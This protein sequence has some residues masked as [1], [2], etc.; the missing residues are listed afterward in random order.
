MD[1]L[2]FGSNNQDDQDDVNSTP[3]KQYFKDE[4]S[5]LDFTSYA[6]TRPDSHRV[7]SA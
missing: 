2:S 7:I 6:T 5:K 1:D 3:A 4:L